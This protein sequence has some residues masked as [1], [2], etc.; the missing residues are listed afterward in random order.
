MDAPVL[1]IGIFVWIIGAGALL[2]Y[3]LRRRLTA[4]LLLWFSA[5]SILYGTRIIVASVFAG[6]SSASRARSAAGRMP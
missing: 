2:M 6:K 4:R 5:F 1:V 3:A